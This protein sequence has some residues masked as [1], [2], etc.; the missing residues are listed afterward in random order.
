MGEKPQ[1]PP[2]PVYGDL[3]SERRW[4]HKKLQHNLRK[5][6][7]DPRVQIYLEPIPTYKQADAHTKWSTGKSIVVTI[8]TARVELVRG[9]VHELLHV[10]L[11]DTLW[12]FSPEVEESIVNA[13][14]AD[15]VA[16]MEE[17]GW[18]QEFQDLISERIAATPPRVRPKNATKVPKLR[19]IET[20]S[21]SNDA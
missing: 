20:K 21:S 7:R 5:L 16:N 2:T 12:P 3:M 13:L 11:D 8:D 10:L 15:I 9:V 19:S 14:E 18:T 6:L 1:T 4:S 17:E